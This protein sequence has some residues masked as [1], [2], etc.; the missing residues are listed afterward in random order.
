MR[1]A[2]TG[3]PKRNARSRTLRSASPSRHASLPSTFT[4]SGAAKLGLPAKLCYPRQTLSVIGVLRPSA[5]SGH[6]H[7]PSAH[8]PAMGGF[9]PQIAL[10]MLRYHPRNC[11]SAPGV[12]LCNLDRLWVA[13]AVGI[14]RVWAWGGHHRWN[15][16][17]RMP[18]A[19]VRGFGILKKCCAEYTFFFTKP[20]FTF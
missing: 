13:V 17:A 1:A 11:A 6:R 19:V 3:V 20:S 14:M 2:G 9:Q 15:S 4:P 10:F 7:T 16:Q 5:C 18:Y 12:S 8:A